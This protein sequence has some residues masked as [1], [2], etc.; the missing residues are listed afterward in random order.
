MHMYLCRYLGTINIILADTLQVKAQQRRFMVAI[1][2]ILPV[3]VIVT[4]AL[5]K[6]DEL[7]AALLKV[8]ITLTLTTAAIIYV[9]V[10]VAS[11]GAASVATSTTV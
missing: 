5:L 8:A 1:P 10:V 2:A 6:V 3:E 7:Q 4:V 9:A 11:V